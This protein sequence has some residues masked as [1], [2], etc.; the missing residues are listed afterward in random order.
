MHK[1]SFVDDQLAAREFHTGDI[2]RVPGNRGT[3]M[4]P[5]VGQVLYSNPGLGTVHVQWPWGDDVEQASEL[6]KDTSG[7]L[8]PPTFDSSYSTNEKSRYTGTI[9]DASED[10]KWRNSLSSEIVDKYEKKTLP[11]YHAACWTWHHGFDEG[12]STSIL[13]RAFASE[14]GG[15]CVKR[16]VSNLYGLSHHLSIYWRDSNRRYRVTKK[17][18]DDGILFCPRCRD[19]L[20]PRVY[21]Q[22]RKIL[23]CNNCGFSIHPRDLK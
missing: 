7:H 4:S 20:K 11:V 6:I 14:F 12:E 17:E 19:F 16:T 15:D 1:L 2:V 18:R 13:H 9:G 22:S 23:M 5:Y 10:N 8:M 3:L 21:R